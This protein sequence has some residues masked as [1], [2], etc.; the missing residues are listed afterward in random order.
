M[1]TSRPVARR[2]RVVAAAADRPLWAPGVEPPSYL[3]GTLAGDRGFDPIGLGADP[4]AMAW[5]IA[6]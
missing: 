3:N 5:Y 4:K 1:Q 2:G 6:A